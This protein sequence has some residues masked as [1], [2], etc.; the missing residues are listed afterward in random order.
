MGTSQ[1]VALALGLVGA[2]AIRPLWRW[3]GMY[4]YTQTVNDVVVDQGERKSP[5]PPHT[6][7]VAT[8][9]AS[10]ILLAVGSSNDVA[11]I[12]LPTAAVALIGLAFLLM[13]ASLWRNVDR[14]TATIERVMRREPTTE[15]TD[16]VGTAL[17]EG[18]VEAVTQGVY[19]LF[20]IRA[21]LRLSAIVALTAGLALLVL[22]VAVAV[23]DGD[24]PEAVT[25]GAEV[26]GVVVDVVELVGYGAL[27]L[28]MLAVLIG[29]LL[30]NEPGAAGGAL[31]F[32][33][34][35]AVS[36]GVGLW[37]GLLDG[38]IDIIEYVF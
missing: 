24:M 8:A 22:A 6:C 2:A 9:L 7:A 27:T 26:Y 37:L 25:S 33:A 1:I 23:N 19:S 38:W 36:I 31:L 18:P 28:I 3:D 34:L 29:A 35:Y 16:L 17:Q 15:G 14:E 12:V 11:R 10:G 20:S 13:G 21:L 4:H 32:L 5:I 30:T